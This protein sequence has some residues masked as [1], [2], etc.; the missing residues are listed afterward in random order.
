MFK[1]YL[2]RFN[3]ERRYCKA[4][5]IFFFKIKINKK[6]NKKG[7]KKNKNTILMIILNY[8]NA[9]PFFF[10]RTSFCDNSSNFVELCS[11]FQNKKGVLI[12]KG[13]ENIVKVLWEIFL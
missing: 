10:F 2:N 13:Y 6:E 3:L 8:I 7:N 1:L 12:K 4:S 11:E 5:K 9:I